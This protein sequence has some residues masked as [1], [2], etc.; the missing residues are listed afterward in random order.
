[1]PSDIIRFSY[2]ISCAAPNPAACVI[3]PHSRAHFVIGL[4]IYDEGREFKF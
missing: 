1:V 3:I 2:E 4:I